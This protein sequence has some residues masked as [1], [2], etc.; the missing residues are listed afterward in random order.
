MSSIKRNQIQAQ[1]KRFWDQLDSSER[2]ELGDQL[3]LGDLDWRDWLT[4]PPPKGFWGAVDAL[5][6]YE[7]F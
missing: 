6:M 3:V 5:R 1:A 7:D 2:F 4:E